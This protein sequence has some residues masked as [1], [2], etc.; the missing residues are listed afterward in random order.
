MASLHCGLGSIPGADF[1]RGLSLLFD[2]F[3]PGCSGFLPA[4][5]SNT[6]NSNFDPE[7]MDIESLSVSSVASLQLQLLNARFVFFTTGIPR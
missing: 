6:L 2:G 5:K 7:T 1:T 4:A 3:S